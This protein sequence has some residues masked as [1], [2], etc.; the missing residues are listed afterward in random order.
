MARHCERTKV[1]LIR[2]QLAQATGLDTEVVA[3]RW[4]SD[5]VDL[6]KILVWR[7]F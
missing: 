3:L 1:S 6:K 4:N 5:L 2:Y 7:A